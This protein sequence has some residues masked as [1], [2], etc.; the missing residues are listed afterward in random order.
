M[1]HLLVAVEYDIH[2]LSPI[3]SW[4]YLSTACIVILD[5][6]HRPGCCMCLALWCRIFLMTKYIIGGGNYFCVIVHTQ[7]GYFLQVISHRF[8]LFRIVQHEEAHNLK[9]IGDVVIIAPHIG[10]IEIHACR[11][12]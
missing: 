8:L 12:C 7:E 4:Y 1:S 9:T 6:H 11:G 5:K 3:V 10:I 2:K